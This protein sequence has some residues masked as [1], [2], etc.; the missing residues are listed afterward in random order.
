MTKI[1]RL[2]D[3]GA[4]GIVPPAERLKEYQEQCKG[5]S[6]K[7]QAHFW[8]DILDSDLEVRRLLELKEK[9]AGRG[10]RNSQ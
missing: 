9:M 5:L 6:R 1:S 2:E 3:F 10:R 4:R 8:L 7:V